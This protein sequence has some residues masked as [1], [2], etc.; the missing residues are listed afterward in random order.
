MTE[1]ERFGYILVKSLFIVPIAAKEHNFST[2]NIIWHSSNA[3]DK[4]YFTNCQLV[5]EMKTNDKCADK[6][7]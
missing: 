3:K 2:I 7:N 5:L 1:N 6:F 4:E